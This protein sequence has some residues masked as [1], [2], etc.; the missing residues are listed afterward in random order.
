M[1][2]REQSPALTSPPLTAP[3]LVRL[4]Q[5]GQQL[6]RTVDDLTG[7]LRHEGVL[8]DLTCA[9]LDGLRT[10]A[11]YARTAGGEVVS[12]AAAARDRAHGA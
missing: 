10:A 1:T 6:R 4:A 3:H 2:T 8:A 12:V 5:L 9:E 7:L 11:A